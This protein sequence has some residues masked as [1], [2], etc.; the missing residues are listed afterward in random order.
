MK[1]SRKSWNN[2]VSMLSAINKTAGRKMQAWIDIHG[3]DDID[4]LVEYAY[5]LTTKYGEAA[6]AMACQMYD[7]IAD[8]QK[9]HVPPAV[10]KP[11]QNIKYVDK[12]VRSTLDRAPS[13]V[14]STI[15]EMVKRTGAE[16]TLKN[17]LRDGAYFAWVP[18]GDTCAFCITLAS[19]GWRRASK[20]TINGDHAE[21]IHKNCDCEFAISFNG[22][23]QIEGY[24]PDKYLQMYENAEGEKWKD[25]VN[26][27]R[28]AQYEA[29]KDMINTKKRIAY[30]DRKVRENI[31]QLEDEAER[32]K[33]KLSKEEIIS[34]RKYA[35]NPGDASPNKLFE[36]INTAL[37]NRDVGNDSLDYHIGNISSGIKK[38]KIEHNFTVYRR[39]DVNPF[40]SMKEGD[41]FRG[42][43][44]FSTSV[45]PKK[46]LKKRHSI[47]I[48][49][50]RGTSGAYIDSLSEF[51]QTEL[52]LDKDVI[53]K[54][55]SNRDN[56]TILEV[57]V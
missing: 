38:F 32:W 53:Y 33:K 57:I 39:V 13:M 40:E 21:H 1:L 7:E 15:S 20:K 5:A 30:F 17:A 19:N 35:Y 56:K 51:D 10:P 48:R 11:T 24:D 41:I 3:T 16:T 31:K 6:S 22:P 34:I 50:K 26:S 42:E 47:E 23:G 25:K 14:P 45:D 9:A 36:R 28:R 54:V 8:I 18:N 2:Y 4:A 43:Q 12:A 44:F 27:M 52:L 46:A 55:K 37:R 49:V 29:N